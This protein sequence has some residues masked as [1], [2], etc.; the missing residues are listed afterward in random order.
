MP[1]ISNKKGERVAM[2]KPQEVSTF[3]RVCEPMCGVL[4]T[5]EDGRITKIRGNPDHVLGKGHFCK[6]AMGAVDITY[7]P[8]RV[9]YPLKRNGG[10]GEFERISWEQAFSEIAEQLS[11]IRSESGD[12][13]FASYIGN[14]PAFIS[15]DSLAHAAMAEALGMKWR[16]S[17]NFEDAVSFVVAVEAIFG[18]MSL[19]RPDFWRSHFALI[20]GANPVGSHGSLISEPIVSKA[21]KSIVD[22][23]GRVV[24]VDPYCS[25]T[26][27][28]FQ[29]QPILAGSDP[30]F[31]SAL[32]KS[33]IDQGFVDSDFVDEHTSGFEQLCDILAP[34]SLEWGERFSGIPAETIREL[35]RQFG[36]AKSACIYGRTGTCTQR[37][38]TLSNILMHLIAV[39]TGNID[40]EGGLSFGYCM[41]QGDGPKTGAARS[42]S[43]GLRDVGG[44]LPPVALPSDILEPGDGQVKALMM[45]GA[46]PALA[47]PVGARLC[48]A[49]QHLDLFFSLDLYVNETN[50]FADYI[51]PCTTMWEREDVPYVSLLGMMLRPSL[52]ASAPVVE[53]R[54]EV[55]EEWEIYFELCN[56]L[57]KSEATAVTPHDM[58]DGIIRNSQFGDKFGAIPDG[59]T[60]E[61]LLND[62]PNG[63]ELMEYMPTGVLGDFV[64]NADKRINL[65]PSE[66]V[67]EM[68]QLF[69]DEFFRQPD[70][71]LRLHSL[72]E[73][74][75]HNTWM[76][77]AQSLAKS[78]REHYA[79]V[80]A[81]DADRYGIEDGS[82]VWIR[83]PYGKLR[84]TARISKRISAGNVALPHG[85][86]HQGGWQIANQRGGVNAN[87][88]ASDNPADSDRVSGGTVLNG[89]PVN[90]EPA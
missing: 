42:R 32:L 14:P 78:R 18:R 63:V 74:L 73:V 2:E 79:R 44:S 19:T 1:E 59:L 3:C 62:Y 34:C 89:I 11:A 52:Y 9:V 4:A 36:S 55:K 40:N 77:N 76:H 65:A 83:S 7:D 47:A 35:A 87:I 46:N 20:V 86:G 22:R 66:L 64:A 48:E 12:A 49:M 68:Q 28:R 13:A 38:G 16:Y 17:V 72:R 26:A 88:L 25:D 24:A 90:I 37:Y 30:Y 75:T 8:D 58:I 82:E 70:F 29:H 60:Y 31:L 85:W 39:V 81:E 6:K 53:R 54:G 33:L 67:A 69:V 27:H 5:V 61:K 10:P 41:L 43:T 56:R 84:I 51:L 23:G 50:R 21:L 45:V 15:A 71:P 57:G 80:S